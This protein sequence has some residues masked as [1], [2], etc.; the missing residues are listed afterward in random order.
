MEP[1]YTSCALILLESPEKVSIGFDNLSL[2]TGQ[3]FKGIKDI[4]IGTHF[5]H[6]LLKIGKSSMFLNFSTG[7][8]IVLKWDSSLEDFIRLPQ[9]EE[10][11]Y[12]S[13]ITDFLLMMVQYPVESLQTWRELT[14]Y[15]TKSVV[16]K[17]DPLK[18]SIS[19]AKREY[20]GSTEEL[21]SFSTSKSIIYYT[22]IPKRWVKHGLSPTEITQCNFDKSCILIDLLQKNF[23]KKSNDLL[24]E[25]Q[26]SFISFLI[27][28]S[29]ESFEQWRNMLML[30]CN[31]DRALR[32]HCEFFIKFIPVLYSQVQ[33][34]PRDLV[35][36]PFLSGSFITS[37]LKAF[38]SLLDN[39]EL[40]RALVSRGEK[41]RNLIRNE[42]GITEFE[43]VDDEEAP[44][45]VD[46]E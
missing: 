15:I 14:C 24:G 13:S 34:L 25:L 20:D 18:H 26:F 6:T 30:V 7:E 5:L 41:L 42:F 39:Q 12:A 33:S 46:M 32:T 10:S 11:L 43:M 29:L 38:V 37:S 44:C 45:I 1:N 8:I 35:Q 16:S 4:P 28:E 21:E 2:K 23:E 19:S 3:L 27:G 9:D 17:L 31:C 40:H 22:S 36:D